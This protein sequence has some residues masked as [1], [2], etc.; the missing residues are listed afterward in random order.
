MKLADALHCTGCGACVKVCPKGAVSMQNDNE[1]FPTPCINAELCVE[2]SLCE[3]TCP[4]LHMPETHPIL[5]AYAVQ[6]ND[7]DALQ[8]S[9][10]G[11]VFTALSRE[12][13]CQDGV[14]Y[15]CVWDEQYNA[16][17][18]RAECEEEIKP[19]RGSKYVWSWAG[20]SYPEAKKDLEAGKK[21]LFTGLP[22]QIAGLK[23]YLRKDY[24]N[25]IL[26]DFLCSGSPSPLALQ[27]YIDTICDRNTSRKNLNLKFRDKDSFGVGVHITYTGK[28]K[29]TKA[30][31]EH[32]T[33]P[34][35]YSFYSRLV[36][37]QSCYQCRYGTD[38]RIS[39][40]TMGDY[41]GVAKY[42]KDMNIR[43][44]VSALLVNT[45]KGDAILKA[46]Q[47]KLTIQPTTKEHIAEANNL[48]CNGAE[49]RN[50]RSKNREAFFKELN[51]N[52]WKSA[53]RKFLL[54]V[55]RLKRYAK[56]KMDP[57]IIRKI[58]AIK[59]KIAH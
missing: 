32:I 33:N 43:E 26:L 46:I 59:R 15:G 38:Q 42:H 16:V 35:Y 23:K 7:R 39:D 51:R 11:G 1:G 17:V 18:R 10:S 45:E 21:V 50:Y 41:W 14:V 56:I 58:K 4:A 8:A 40:L 47:D 5:A 24:D 34:Y 30:V 27:K 19:M 6:L 20:D 57:E 29:K 48:Y 52:G 55:T 13:F 28:K 22:C 36:D 2:C 37:R 49:P 31:G 25:L 53:E 3:K 9:T 12:I 54:N 44:G